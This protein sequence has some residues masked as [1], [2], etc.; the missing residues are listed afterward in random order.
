[1]I[2]FFAI[3]KKGEN[4]YIQILNEYFCYFLVYVESYLNAVRFRLILHV[5]I[6]F[7]SK[8]GSDK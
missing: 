6:S 4:F 2:H 7:Y 3:I 5:L 8:I 1:M